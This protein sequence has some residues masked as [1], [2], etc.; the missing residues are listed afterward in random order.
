MGSGLTYIDEVCERIYYIRDHVFVFFTNQTFVLNL[1]QGMKIL[2]DKDV[3]QEMDI[4][5]DMK[6]L[7]DMEG[8]V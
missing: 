6:I 2:H 4:F 5:R 8:L 3:F 1:R 7:Q